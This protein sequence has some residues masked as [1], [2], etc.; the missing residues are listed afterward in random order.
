MR[1]FRRG[2]SDT[3]R[4]ATT[5]CERWLKRIAHLIECKIGLKTRNI[6]IEVNEDVHCS[7]YNSSSATGSYFC[8]TLCVA[9]ATVAAQVRKIWF[10]QE[11]YYPYICW[12]SAVLSVLNL[13]KRFIPD[14]V[15][16]CNKKRNWTAMM[17]SLIFIRLHN[18]AFINLGHVFKCLLCVSCF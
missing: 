4:N 2:G 10:I 12:G 7:P 11:A 16:F 13:W 17:I 3:P 15:L 18:Y 14:S 5:L 9:I 1:I 8:M 6:I